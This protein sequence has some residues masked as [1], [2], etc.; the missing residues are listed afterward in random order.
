MV[1]WNGLVKFL[2]RQEGKFIAS[3]DELIY[4]KEKNVNRTG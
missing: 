2:L 1:A 3:G 4:D